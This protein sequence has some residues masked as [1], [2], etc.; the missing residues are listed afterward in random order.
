MGITDKTRKILWG[1]SGNR[2]AICKRELTMDASPGNDESIVGDECHIVARELG[3]S[4]N[5]S[6]FP[7]NKLNSYENLI[8][9]CKIH[10]KMI[11]DQ[12]NTYTVETLRKIKKQHAEYVR[13]GLEPVVFQGYSHEP[14]V[15]VG[16]DVVEKKIGIL[17]SNLANLSEQIEIVRFKGKLLAEEYYWNGSTSPHRLELYQV[18]S[19]RYVVYH[20]CVHNADYEEATLIGANAWDEIDPPLTLEQLQ[21]DFPS[22]ATQARLFRIRTLE[23]YIANSNCS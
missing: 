13:R 22:L 6:S 16:V 19:G 21:E 9:L 1:H 2:C 4:R 23:L 20:W 14:K 17:S 8:L 12:V 11:D 7:A 15:P 10:H 3:G 5:D 18:L